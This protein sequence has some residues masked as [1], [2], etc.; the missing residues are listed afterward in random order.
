M[1][2]AFL[3]AFFSLL[4]S[5]LFCPQP[6]PRAERSCCPA[7]GGWG[8]KLRGPHLQSVLECLEGPRVSLGLQR[9]VGLP[10]GAEGAAS[11][12]V[13]SSIFRLF[14]FSLPC[15]YK[16][17]LSRLKSSSLGHRVGGRGREEFAD[18][19]FPRGKRAFCS[20]S[21]SWATPAWPPQSRRWRGQD[22]SWGRARFSRGC[23]GLV[24]AEKGAEH[25]LP[26]LPHS[27]SPWELQGE[28]RR[29][30]LSALP[31][32]QPHHLAS[33]QHLHLPQ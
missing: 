30:A 17:K 3:P 26:L 16:P 2:P 19:G 1:T 6:C 10:S 12:L 8:E 29:G 22:V 9:G 25:A 15:L 5:P 21:W 33:R 24:S 32:Q 23:G 14:L 7:P 31:P 13:G 27:L 20:C 28:A 18:V 11:S 4:S